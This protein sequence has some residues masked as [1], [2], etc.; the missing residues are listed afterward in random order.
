MFTFTSILNGETGSLNGMELDRTLFKSV[1]L[2]LLRGLVL[3]RVVRPVLEAGEVEPSSRRVCHLYS[4]TEG[5]G[6]SGVVGLLTVGDDESRSFFFERQCLIRE[7][8]S[9]CSSCEHGI[10]RRNSKAE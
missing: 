10:I 7:W 1:E 9:K 8:K 2:A 6:R 4:S 3:L 5:A